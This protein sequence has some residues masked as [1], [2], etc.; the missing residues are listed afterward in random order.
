M[1]KMKH[2]FIA[3]YFVV[4]TVFSFIGMFL[5]ESVDVGG[6]VLGV[7]SAWIIG[8]VGWMVAEEWLN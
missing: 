7:I 1:N 5:A 6:W 4:V 2:P 3:A 8:G